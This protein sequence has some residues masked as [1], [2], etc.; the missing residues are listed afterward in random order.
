MENRTLQ[1]VANPKET[2]QRLV[3]ETQL[4][5]NFACLLTT[6]STEGLLATD[7]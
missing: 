5:L 4:A 2:G 3:D 6:S 1:L 7:C